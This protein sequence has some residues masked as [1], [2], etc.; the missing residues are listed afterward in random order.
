MQYLTFKVYFLV[1]K[2]KK[3]GGGVESREPLLFALLPFLKIRLQYVTYLAACGVCCYGTVLSN[4]CSLSF[5]FKN[6]KEIKAIYK[7]MH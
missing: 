1:K 7:N 4:A 6:M 2:K 5:N 3:G